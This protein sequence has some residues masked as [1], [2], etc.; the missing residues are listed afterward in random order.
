MRDVLIEDVLRF[1][2]PLGMVELALPHVE[3]HAVE[4]ESK[5]MSLMSPSV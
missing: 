5:A 1:A 2:V 3:Q 4:D